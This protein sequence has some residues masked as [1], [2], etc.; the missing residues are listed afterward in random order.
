MD[1]IYY[2]EYNENLYK[3]LN[4]ESKENIYFDNLDEFNK[5][6]KKNLVCSLVSIYY[7]NLIKCKCKSDKCL[8]NFNSIYS[9]ILK[10]NIKNDLFFS[11][12][13][14]YTNDECPVYEEVEL[15]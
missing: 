12:K 5:F 6:I 15:I 10:N 4:I 14:I 13:I 2:L 9:Y 1:E 11:N 3:I 7:P 8:D